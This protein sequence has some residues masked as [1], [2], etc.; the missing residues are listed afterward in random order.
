MS[1]APTDGGDL[2]IDLFNDAADLVDQ[3]VTI[4]LVQ[5]ETGEDLGT[6]TR[7]ITI[8]SGAIVRIAAGMDIPP[9]DLRLTIDPDNTITETDAGE[10]NNV[11]E[12]PI[13]IQVQFIDLDSGAGPC[14]SFLDQVA[15][16]RFR[17]RLG[18]RPPGGAVNWV[19]EN[20][21]PWMGTADYNYRT[22]EYTNHIW[23][24]SDDPF[25]IYEF[26]MPAADS[27]IVWGDG[28]EDDAGL[29][30]DDYAGS[31]MESFGRDVN[32]GSR[33]NA[34]RS[35]SSGYL[36][37]PD[38][39]SLGWGSAEDGISMRYIITRVH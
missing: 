21:Y 10:H 8:P 15:E 36:S 17:L 14:E 31:F 2:Y 38:G 9:Y 13:L 12:T 28:T 22:G 4:N 35:T 6:I 26:E 33:T 29:A 34:Y 23:D 5:M 1:S 7:N 19:W 37:C 18:H 27:L 16:F 32:Y 25:F 24:V 39:S 20:N 11:Y 3:D 30:A